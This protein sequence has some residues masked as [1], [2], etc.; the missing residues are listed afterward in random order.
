MTATFVIGLLVAAI[1]SCGFGAGYW[2]RAQISARRRKR[3]RIGTL[4]VDRT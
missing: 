4:V 3:Y 1:F 2:V